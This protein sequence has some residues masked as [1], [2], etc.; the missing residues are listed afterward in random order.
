MAL[1]HFPITLQ[2]KIKKDEYE[3][4][5]R[6]LAVNELLIDQIEEL[7]KLDTIFRYNFK[8]QANILRHEC[9]DV[10]SKF[11]KGTELLKD[12]DKLHKKVI[13]QMKNNLKKIQVK[14]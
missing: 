1:E 13:D 7:E 9:L 10:S 14:V 4:L 2:G 11:F 6:F 8:K 5:M 12:Y 3:I